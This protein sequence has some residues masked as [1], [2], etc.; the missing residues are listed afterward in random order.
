MKRKTFLFAGMTILGT[1]LFVAGFG[2]PGNFGLPEN[3][4]KVLMNIGGLLA[5]RGASVLWTDYLESTDPAYRRQNR[6]EE[7]DER[8]TAIR[9]RAKALTGDILQWVVMAGGVLAIGLNAPVW[10]AMLAFGVVAIK[11]LTEAYLT[12][13]Y[14]EEM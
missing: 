12:G 5:I 13:R 8:N 4:N 2:L 3:V 9:N 1:V 7:N 11:Y 10:V 6:I 14:N